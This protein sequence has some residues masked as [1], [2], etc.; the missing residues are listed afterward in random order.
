M[1]AA[2]GVLIGL[3]V[4]AA[5]AMGWTCVAG[6]HSDAARERVPPGSTARLGT[7][8]AG[9]E[10]DLRAHAQPRGLTVFEF[11]AP[12][13]SACT[14]LAPRLERLVAARDDATLRIVQI[15]D[16]DSPVARQHR[17]RALPHLVLWQDGAPAVHGVDDVLERLATPPR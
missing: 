13:C 3:A 9:E 2:R 11:A 1:A 5:A 10:V 16:W 14:R 17:I 6:G 7:I 4:A 8:S 15:G 12:W